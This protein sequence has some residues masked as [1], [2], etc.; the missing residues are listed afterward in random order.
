MA[1]PR[2]ESLGDEATLCVRRCPL[3]I[4]TGPFIRLDD[5]SV[6]VRLVRVLLI[7]CS[8]FESKVNQSQSSEGIVRRA[9]TCGTL[10]DG[11]IRGNAK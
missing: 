10:E 4:D 5:S 1:R 8:E 2:P 9:Q 11:N 7:V 3:D 6:F